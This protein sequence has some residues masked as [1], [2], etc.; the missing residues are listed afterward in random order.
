MEI[1]LAENSDLSGWVRLVEPMI[2]TFF[3]VCYLL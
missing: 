3:I 1:R 2:N